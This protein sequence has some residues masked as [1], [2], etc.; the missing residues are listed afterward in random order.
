[1]NK[2]FILTE[3]QAETLMNVLDKWEHDLEVLRGELERVTI[4][5]NNKIDDVAEDMESLN[6]VMSSVL[7]G[8]Y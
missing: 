7:Y 1:M 3:N 6:R 2:V 4:K 5:E 8:G